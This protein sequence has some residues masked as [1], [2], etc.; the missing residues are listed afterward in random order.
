MRTFL[1]KYVAGKLAG[2]GGSGFDKVVTWVIEQAEKPIS[3]LEKAEEVIGLFKRK[4][5]RCC[6]IHLSYRRSIG[7][8]LCQ[9]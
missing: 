9:N 1:I 2:I 6:G 7:I 3:G 8:C 4:M 5:G